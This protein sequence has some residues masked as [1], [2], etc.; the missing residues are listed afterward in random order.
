MCNTVQLN[1]VHAGSA[2]WRWNLVISAGGRLWG[3]GQWRVF[4]DVIAPAWGHVVNTLDVVQ[5]LEYEKN[6]EKVENT[7]NNENVN[8]AGKSGKA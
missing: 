1:A 8:D 4:I 2:S 3:L 5:S 7:K 6:I